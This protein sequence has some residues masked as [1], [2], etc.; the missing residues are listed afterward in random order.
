[1]QAIELGIYPPHQRQRRFDLRTQEERDDDRI[2]AI[3]KRT[4][5]LLSGEFNPEHESNI[6]EALDNLTDEQREI[7]TVLVK[8][9]SNK[10]SA[11]MQTWVNQWCELQARTKSEQ[12]LQK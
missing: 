6:E 1:M 11:I 8:F 3:N 4:A 7:R 5:E 12:E 9:Q 2:E 10:L